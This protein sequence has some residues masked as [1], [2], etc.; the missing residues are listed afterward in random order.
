MEVAS[1]LGLWVAPGKTLN[2]LLLVASS[3]CPRLNSI[4]L[5]AK[6][7]ELLTAPQDNH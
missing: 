5:F 6:S 3:S 7:Q 2:I 1:N 4:I